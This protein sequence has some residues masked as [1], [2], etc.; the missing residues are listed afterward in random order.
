VKAYY[1]LF[2]SLSL[3]LSVS[4]SL[5]K[6]KRKTNFKFA[7]LSRVHT[8]MEKDTHIIVLFG[9]VRYHYSIRKIY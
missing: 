7:R 6:K 2:L 3:G 5:K 4:L 1:E 8:I 9:S